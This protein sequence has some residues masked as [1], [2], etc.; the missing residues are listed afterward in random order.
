MNNYHKIEV[1]E[2]YKTL[3][4]NKE[5]L[6]DEEANKRLNIYGKNILPKE[7]KETILQIF[8]SQFKSPIIF[9]MLLAAIFSLIAKEYIDVIAIFVIVL[10]DAV[11][12][13]IQEYS[14]GKEAEAL[15]NLIKIKCKVYRNGKEK[16]IDSEKIVVGDVI[17]LESGDK[18]PADARIIDSI[19]LYLNIEIIY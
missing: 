3:D 13:T 12:G 18:V 2:V 16:V 5:G 6:S 14:A 7:K 11:V 17:L 4:T 15:Q 10:V 8:A 9:I 19:N 1:E